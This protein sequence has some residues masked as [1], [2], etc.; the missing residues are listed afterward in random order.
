MAMNDELAQAYNDQ[1]NLEFESMYVY[2]QM[3]AHLDGQ[4][5]PGLARWMRVQAGEERQHAMRF[6]DFLLDRGVDITLQQIAAPEVD[7]SSTVAVFEQALAHEQ[8]VSASIDALY[9]RAT[10]LAD[11]ASFPILQWFVDEQ[12][13]EESTVGQIV[14]RLRMAGGDPSALLLLDSELGSRDAT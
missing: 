13:E 7:T 6:F 1:I 12:V 14:E 5:L 8:K 4:N 11:Y 9:R 2:L 3:A 10:E